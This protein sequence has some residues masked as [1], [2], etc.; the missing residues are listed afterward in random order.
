MSANQEPAQSGGASTLSFL[1]TSSPSNDTKDPVASD[2]PA[3]F[4]SQMS[5]PKMDPSA[6][7][8]QESPTK[9]FF[10]HTVESD[11]GIIGTPTPEARIQED[12]TISEVAT[13]ALLGE[14]ETGATMSMPSDRTNPS[15][16]VPAAGLNIAH[17]EN[18]GDAAALASILSIA[19]E[20]SP[21]STDPTV[22]DVYRNVVKKTLS[23][24][25]TQGGISRVRTYTVALV[26]LVLGGGGLYAYSNDMIPALPTDEAPPAALNSAPIVPAASIGSSGSTGT[27]TA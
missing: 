17:D 2:L 1:A 9:T 26:A 5:G 10:A 11:A 23:S 12:T 3:D 24:E 13:D 27:G 7:E 4:F 22:D 19:Q 14:G 20:P 25:R 15:E 21:A 18:K 16:N 6:S 8:Q